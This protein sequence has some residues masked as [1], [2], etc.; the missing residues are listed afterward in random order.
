MN[1]GTKPFEEVYEEQFSYVYNY[2][3][4]ML[5]NRETTE[6]IVSTAFLKAFRNYSSYDPAKSG[7]R[8]WL[9]RIAKNC[10]IDHVRSKA[11]KEVLSIEDI[12]EPFYEE[13]FQSLQDDANRRAFQL[14]SGLSRSER[15]F[16]GLRYRLDLSNE[17]IAAITGSNAKAVSEK[18]RRLLAKCKKLLE[19]QG[20]TAEDLFT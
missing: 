13:E 17:E 14:L 10:A 6:D 16:L 8:T 9:C 11:K 7:I 4:M 3:Y 5:L 18:Y 15:E 19:S 1:E 20:L 2:I 12:R